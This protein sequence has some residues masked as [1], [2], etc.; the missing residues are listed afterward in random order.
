MTGAASKLVEL[1]AKT[2][3]QLLAVAEHELK[4]AQILASVAATTESP[5]YEQ[6]M[7][8]VEQMT[9][10]QATIPG[11]YRSEL[12]SIR[13]AIAEVR[14]ALARVPAHRVEQDTLL[15]IQR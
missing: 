13:S 10:L 1:R 15:A 9:K 12:E 8:I 3:T 14:L 6:A 11:A 4:R 7:K 5:F 2:D